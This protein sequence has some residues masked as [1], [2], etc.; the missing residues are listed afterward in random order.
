MKKLVFT[1]FFVSTLNLAQA[2]T[3]KKEDVGFLKCVR[4]I[5]ATKR[6]DTNTLQKLFEMVKAYKNTDVNDSMRSCEALLLEVKEL[7]K[8]S[9]NELRDNLE[10]VQLGADY[11]SGWNAM[12]I[13]DGMIHPS[14]ECA[15]NSV[16]VDAA[17]GLGG[18]VGLGIGSCQREDGR[19]F[20]MVAP[21]FS[22]AIGGGAAVT[23]GRQHFTLRDEKIV[24][25]GGFTLGIILVQREIK[26]DDSA[27]GLGLAVILEA[28][29][30]IPLKVLPVGNNFDKIRE[31]LTK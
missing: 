30:V 26:G 9:K 4:K 28:G 27:F 29:S 8:I 2:E 21:R 31:Y 25:D 12:H 18:G 3:T 5:T 1:L 6:A 22:Y 7:P 17:L 11:E 13:L 23:I 10:H 15:L 24:E 14:S 19:V 16:G 20:V